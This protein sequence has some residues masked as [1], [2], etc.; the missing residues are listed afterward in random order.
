MVSSLGISWVSSRDGSIPAYA[1]PASN[2]A[3][4]GPLYVG[5]ANFR[6]DL[7]PAKV[8]PNHHTA[9]VSFAGSEHRVEKY[10]V[11]TVT[12]FYWN[13]ALF[14]IRKVL[15]VYIGQETILTGLF[16]SF[17]VSKGTYQ[18]RFLET[19]LYRTIPILQSLSFYYLDFV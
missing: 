9:Y 1:V 8:V 11:K 18:D 19:G 16:L 4:G 15:G 17:R 5:R 7:L 6:S 12:A 13:T 2:D 10:E 3:D 14:R